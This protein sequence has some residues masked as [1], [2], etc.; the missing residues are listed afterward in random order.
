MGHRNCGMDFL[1]A[2]GTTAAYGYSIVSII[3][4]CMLPGFHGHHFFETSALLL[5][6]VVMGKTA[7]A[8]ARGKTSDA[9]TNLMKL[10]PLT[11]L[12]RTSAP[13]AESGK[14]GASAEESAEWLW[15]EVDVSL[16]RPGDVVKVL[17]GKQIPTDGRVISGASDVDE[18]MLTGEAMP[19]AKKQGSEVFGSTLNQEG[20]IVVEATRTGAKTALAQIIR[21]VEDAQMSKAPIQNFAASVCAFAIVTFLIWLFASGGDFVFSFLFG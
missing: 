7:E 19:I 13:G 3:A 15:K 21:L 5:T 8:I 4:A 14:R 1:I 2:M 16:V 11:A 18:S 6:F 17:P 12:L 10:Q 20:T 9:L